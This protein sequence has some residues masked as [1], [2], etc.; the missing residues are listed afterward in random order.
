MNMNNS[1]LPTNVADLQ[2]MVIAERQA[3]HMALQ[4]AERAV[5][6]AIDTLRAARLWSVDEREQL[7]VYACQHL[8]GC[9]D[10]RQLGPR[11]AWHAGLVSAWECLK[12]DPEA[13]TLCELV[14]RLQLEVALCA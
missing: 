1:A 11:G 7:C 4:V 2:R 9:D 13:H 14:M 10:A 8:T 3:K 6:Q 12:A 5:V